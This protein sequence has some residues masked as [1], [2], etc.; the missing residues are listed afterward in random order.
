VDDLPPLPLGFRR[1]SGKRNPPVKVG[2][3]YVQLRNGMLPDEPW[4]VAQTQSGQTRWK[5][6][7]VPDPF[8]VVAVKEG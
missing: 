7:E 3:Y 2:K 5:W 1:I 8:D 4:P 6:G